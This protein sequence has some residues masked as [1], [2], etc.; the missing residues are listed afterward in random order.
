MLLTADIYKKNALSVLPHQERR[1]PARWLI[2]RLF[3]NGPEFHLHR[4]P[5]K[6]GGNAVAGFCRDW[7]SKRKPRAV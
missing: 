1:L 5:G 3:R 2:L 7:N 4:L 6:F